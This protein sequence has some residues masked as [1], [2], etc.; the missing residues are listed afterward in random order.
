MTRFSLL[1]VLLFVLALPARAAVPADAVS[2]Y[3]RGEYAGAARVFMEA[4]N[5]SPG[6]AEVRVWLGKSFLKLR[7][8][9]KA[10]DEFEKAVQLQPS[11]AQ[12]HL[13]LGR[14][15]GSKASNVVFFKALGWARRLLK[16]FETARRLAPDSLEPRFDL[17][18]FYLN[19]PGVV[20]G[21][22]DKAEAEA[23]AI[24]ELNPRK[25]YV[26]RA[27]IL[28]HDKKWEEAKKEL[29]QATIDYPGDPG[30]YKDLAG[31][32]LDRQDFEGALQYGTKAL[33]LQKDSRSIQLIVAA[34]ETQ[35]RKNLDRAFQS[36]A[37]LA[38]GP[39]TDSD[40]SFEEVYYWLGRCH[41]ARGNRTEARKAFESALAYNP[42]YGR[43]KEQL[44]KLR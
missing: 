13:W 2:L 10:V 9:D 30:T 23:R 18:E 42:D 16:E 44:S 14:A 31:Y 19:A 37:A 22:K 15:Y 39:L 41:L 33:S 7:Q 40:P 5:A 24:S 11:N 36:L 34:A 6:D 4:R 28:K 27:E 17:L 20:G 3:H 35:L 25:G 8:W 38:S 32:L 1:A 43:A 29:T 12:Y 26:A 21:G